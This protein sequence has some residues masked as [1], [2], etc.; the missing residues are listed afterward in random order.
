MQLNRIHTVIIGAGVQGTALALKLLHGGDTNF[1]MLDPQPVMGEWFRNTRNQR[2]NLLRTPHTANLDPSGDAT[3]LPA[4]TK[5][6]ASSPANV[7]LFNR[8]HARLISS[9]QLETFR[10]AGQVKS[11]IP[12]G[13]E[14]IVEA[15]INKQSI[16][17]LT[18]N[19]VCAVGLGKPWMPDI[20][21]NVPSIVH[22][23]YVNL[24][25]TPYSDGRVAIVGSGLT[26]TTL[27]NY[28]AGRYVNV[29]LFCRSALSVQQLET[30]PE[31][32]PGQRLHDGFLDTRKMTERVRQLK[33][34]R[35]TNV[36]T[37][38]AW[39][40]LV[41]NINTGLVTLHSQGAIESVDVDT[42][43]N[44]QIGDKVFE[45]II[46]ATGY[47]IDA[48]QMP[49]LKD[50]IDPNT[51]VA[52]GL[53]ILNDDCSHHRLKNL[54]FMGKLAEL[55]VGPLGRNIPGALYASKQI[56][57]RILNDT[58]PVVPVGRPSKLDAKSY[59]LSF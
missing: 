40:N 28:Y 30:V 13:N 59:Q 7:E 22:A 12:A 2:L 8:F 49:M 5:I 57:Q 54:F 35:A 16:H 34:A 14:F 3:M 33:A 43:G 31:W 10:K 53:P 50:V 42:R 23:H 48:T 41:T 58:L 25:G 9:N 36:V 32:R 21:V 52:S 15:I 20:C 4:R 19:V 45:K 6:D 11:I 17:Y 46:F 55:T 1:I 56:S 37:P 26:A 27:A 18:R 47:K 51:D 29:D 38:D 24:L 44:G 39:D